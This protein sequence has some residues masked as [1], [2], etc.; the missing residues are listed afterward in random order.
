ML[1]VSA[2]LMNSRLWFAAG[3][4]LAQPQDER[5]WGMLSL[6]VIVAKM[7]SISMMAYGSLS[8]APKFGPWMLYL[9]NYLLNVV[10]QSGGAGTDLL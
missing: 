10:P 2:L 9:R 4:H 8:A 3:F 5:S 7:H 1:S 6:H